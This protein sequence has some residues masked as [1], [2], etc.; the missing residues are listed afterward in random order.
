MAASVTGSGASETL[1][2]GAKAFAA[3][4]PRLGRAGRLFGGSAAAA[5]AAPLGAGRFLG[6]ICPWASPPDRGEEGGSE[7][8]RIRMRAR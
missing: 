2:S 5:A 7:N 6:G 8:C 3:A 1:G 4:A